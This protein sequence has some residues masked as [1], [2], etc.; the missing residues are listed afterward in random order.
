MELTKR[1]DIELLVSMHIME[2]FNFVGA[3]FPGILWIFFSYELEVHNLYNRTT[4]L[5]PN[6]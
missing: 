2:L 5:H 1:W 3:Q 4:K 6:L